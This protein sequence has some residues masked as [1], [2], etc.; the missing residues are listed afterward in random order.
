MK[1]I[2]QDP[3]FDWKKSFIKI[4][5]GGSYASSNVELKFEGN[6]CSHSLAIIILQKK[7]FGRSHMPNCFVKR[8]I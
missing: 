6:L 8:Y 3:S 1:S 2:V 4:V 7:L 5:S